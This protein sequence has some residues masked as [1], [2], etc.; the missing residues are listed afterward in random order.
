MIM[1]DSY[2]SGASQYYVCVLVAKQ[3]EEAARLFEGPDHSQKIH[4]QPL[5]KQAFSLI[6]VSLK[7]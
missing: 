6:S 1:M 7:A 4:G 2:E 5:R 3:L